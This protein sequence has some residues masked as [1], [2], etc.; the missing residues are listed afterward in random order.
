MPLPPSDSGSLFVRTDAS[1]TAAW[2]QLLDALMDWEDFA[3]AADA[4]GVFR[5]VA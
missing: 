2:R 3:R 5:G 1:R 4:D